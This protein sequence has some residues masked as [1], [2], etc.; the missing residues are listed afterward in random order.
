M[1][2][3]AAND[4]VAFTEFRNH[5]WNFLGIILQIRVHGDDDLA[6]R[7]CEARSQC[8]CF[9]KIPSESQCPH[10]AACLG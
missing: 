10:R 3:P 4:I 5:P 1:L 8:C 7:F 9:P 6:G 2:F